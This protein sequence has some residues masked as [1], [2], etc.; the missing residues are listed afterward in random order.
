VLWVASSVLWV[1]SSVLWVASPV[2]HVGVPCRGTKTIA[3]PGLWIMNWTGC[4]L[5]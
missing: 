4:G 2:L 3:N 5:E 1:A